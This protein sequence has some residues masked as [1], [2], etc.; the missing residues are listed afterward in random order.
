VCDYEGLGGEVP[1]QGDL[2]VFITPQRCAA[3]IRGDSVTAQL[4][5]LVLTPTAATVLAPAQELVRL[6]SVVARPGQWFFT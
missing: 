3:N 6:R 2:Q 4:S 5:G 1:P